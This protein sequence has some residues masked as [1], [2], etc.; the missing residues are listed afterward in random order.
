MAKSP[1]SPS[2][3]SPSAATAVD[4]KAPSERK[5]K[6]DEDALPDGADIE[7]ALAP[8][9]AF[10]TSEQP[11]RIRTFLHKLSQNP[12]QVLLLEGG[13]PDQRLHAALYWALLLNCEGA[14]AQAFGT[15]PASMQA[16][17][18][19]LMPM[20]APPPCSRHRLR[21]GLRLGLW[22]RLFA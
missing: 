17:L 19:G 1:S 6:S 2:R 5:K 9:R 15:P 3:K 8:L 18:P 4:G 7:D 13:N 10:D 22:A 14:S 21:A 12:P 11:R 20:T 16:G